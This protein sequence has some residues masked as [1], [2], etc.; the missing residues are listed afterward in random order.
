MS[1][2]DTRLIGGIYRIGQTIRSGGML[3]IYTAYNRITN[4]VVG[5]YVI[6]FAPTMQTGAVQPLL[7]SLEPRR[8]LQ[9][10][11]V[12]RI[13]NWGIDGN[14]AYIAT[15]PPRGVT[16]QHIVDTENI[17]IARAIELTK[18]MTIGV[19]Q[20]H[21]KGV[22]GLDL[23]PQ[24]IT[25]DSVNVTDRVQIDDIGLRSLL[26]ELGY[27]H[28]QQTN[29]LGDLD[30]RYAPPEYING[31][32][33]GSWSDVYQLGL[34]LFALITGRLPFVGRTPA[35]TGIM[36][37]NN[38]VPRMLQFAHETPQ[39]IQ[40]IVDCALAKEPAQRFANAGAL[41]TALEALQLPAKQ[42][43]IEQIS[44]ASGILGSSFT[45]E[46]T[47]VEEATPVG[48]PKQDA[49]ISPV[50]T[51]YTTEPTYEVYAYLVFEKEL[52]PV[53]IPLLQRN[54]IIGRSDPKRGYMPDI[55]L[56]EFDPKMTVS[57]QQARIRFEE[58]FFYIED[59]KSRNKTRLGELALTPFKAELLQNGDILHFG[60]V[61]MHFEIPGMAKPPV[62]HE[63]E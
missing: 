25:V 12:L 14:R 40:L 9:S 24:L 36:Q 11:H 29:D 32:N 62:F 5:L 10:P 27:L 26:H 41:L 58:T 6:T 22:A 43:A 3:S 44:T 57:R 42:P 34:L 31:G 37:N 8:S 1:Q 61:Q 46:M 21:E 54:I 55:D 56:T 51:S 15:D 50:P 28:S 48:T 2:R 18:Q 59:L 20:L 4:D 38:P 49:H 23:R 35:E 47:S 19:K 16:L 7:Q 33:I 17:D 60:S 30:P 52:M 39:A 13:Y 45:H 63:Q 53:R